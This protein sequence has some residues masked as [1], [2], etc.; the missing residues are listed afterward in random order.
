MNI[1]HLGCDFGQ[2]PRC[3]NASY[4]LEVPVLFK[5]AFGEFGVRLEAARPLLQYSG[6][7][8][9]SC[10]GPFPKFMLVFFPRCFLEALTAHKKIIGVLFL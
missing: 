1:S 9:F 10:N 3:P 7:V 6:I 8:F 4:S 5:N 2:L